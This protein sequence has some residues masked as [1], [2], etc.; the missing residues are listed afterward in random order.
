MVVAFEQQG[1]LVI[2]GGLTLIQC[3]HEHDDSS[4]SATADGQELAL[5][6]V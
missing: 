2:V 4:A 1:A 6:L 5:V 3:D